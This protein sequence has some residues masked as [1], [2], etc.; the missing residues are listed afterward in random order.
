MSQ[1]AVFNARPGLA[2]LLRV[3]NASG[4]RPRPRPPVPAPAP[5]LVP[6][7]G[8]GSR[9]DIGAT[10][11]GRLPPAVEPGRPMIPAAR[12]PAASAAAETLTE[13]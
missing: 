3:G 11:G 5:F 6:P 8:P 9:G 7:P 4:P 10:G 2:R 12:Q 13:G 1:S